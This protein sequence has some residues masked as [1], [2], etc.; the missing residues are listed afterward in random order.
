MPPSPRPAQPV[1]I[2][3]SQRF[4][5][6]DWTGGE[7]GAGGGGW[8]PRPVSSAEFLEDTNHDLVAGQRLRKGV[9]LSVVW[10]GSPLPQPRPVHYTQSKMVSAT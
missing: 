1:A 5:A 2:E 9:R 4:G 7:G 6:D 10:G 3:K 8:L